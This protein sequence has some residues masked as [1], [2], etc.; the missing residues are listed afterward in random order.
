MTRA[1]A[2]VQINVIAAGALPTWRTGMAVNEWKQLAAS[3]PNAL[4]KPAWAEGGGNWV[5]DWSGMSYDTVNDVV[6]SCANGGHTDYSGNETNAL[7]LKAANPAWVTRQACSAAGTWPAQYGDPTNTGYYTDGRPVSVHSY[8]T[9]HFITQRNRAMRFGSTATW[10]S[11]NGTK[12]VNGWN[13]ATN[14]WDAAGTYPNIPLS[15]TDDAICQNPTTG[16]VYAASQNYG[17]HRWNQA[18]NTWTQ[19][20]TDFG[21]WTAN[22]AACAYDTTRN[23]ILYVGVFG[24]RVWNGSAFSDPGLNGAAASALTSGLKTGLGLVYVPAVDAYFARRGAAGS[25]VYRINASTFEVTALSTTGGGS[26]PATADISGTPENVYTRWLY[27][28]NLGGCIYIPNYAS[29][30]WFLR[31]H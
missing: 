10:S 30:A 2:T 29:P 24:N 7:D 20:T 22:R 17:L 8:W 6:Y 12:H 4:G 15:A 23:R 13:P 21:S 11:G 27:S 18:L 25:A 9:Q 5:D 16:D 19:L 28:P 1:T 14:A 26:V 31:L 3:A